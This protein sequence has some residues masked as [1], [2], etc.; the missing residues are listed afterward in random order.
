M[1]HEV[2][3]ICDDIRSEIGRK[4]S[5][6]GVFDE[7]LLIASAPA[8]IARLGLFQKWSEVEGFPKLVVEITGSA[9]GGNSFKAQGVRS[10]EAKKKHSPVLKA[11]MVFGPLDIL[12]AG[13]IEFRTYFDDAKEPNYVHRLNVRVGQKEFDESMRSG[14]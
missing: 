11:L 5:L 13:E 12:S 2:T 1:R 14:P 9:I 3:I 10:D 6:M 4:V 8:R 7:A